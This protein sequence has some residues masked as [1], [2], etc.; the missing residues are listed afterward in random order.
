[1]REVCFSVTMQRMLDEI[2]AET[3]GNPK[4]GSAPG[5]QS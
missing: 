5:K 1:M 2:T 3:A 4:A